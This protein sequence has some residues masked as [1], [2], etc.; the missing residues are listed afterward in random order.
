[1]VMIDLAIAIDSRDVIIGFDFEQHFI[2][3]FPIIQIVAAF[4]Q[5]FLV[6]CS[7]HGK[8]GPLCVL[9]Q[10]ICPEEITEVHP[11]FSHIKSINF[12]LALYKMR[13][14]RSWVSELYVLAISILGSQDDIILGFFV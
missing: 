6:C 3:T 10:S 5:A 4:Y 7:G 9:R 14:R 8:N 13:S 11:W 12:F 2:K 1:M